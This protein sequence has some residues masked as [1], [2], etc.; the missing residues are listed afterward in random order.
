MFLNCVFNPF[1][2]S[3]RGGKP[4]GQSGEVVGWHR[5]VTPVVEREHIR[6]GWEVFLGE[7][8]DFLSSSAS[9]VNSLHGSPVKNSLWVLLALSLCWERGCW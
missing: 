2:R 4:R 9:P 5:E 1:D 3:E 8:W 6:Q 7:N